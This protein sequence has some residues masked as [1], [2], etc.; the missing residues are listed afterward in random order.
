[1][2]E[3]GLS[4][5]LLRRLVEQDGTRTFAHFVGADGQ[6]KALLWGE[7]FE[8][9]SSFARF[10]EAAG[11]ERRETVF[12]L[13]P[14]GPELLGA[15]IGAM[16]HRAL[17]ALLSYPSSKVPP[18]VYAKNLRGVL[19]VTGARW[20]VTTRAL[21]GPVG[22]ALE[23]ARSRVLWLEDRKP[24][25]K[26]TLERHARSVADVPPDEVALLQHSSGSTGLQKGVALSHRSVLR[27]IEHYARAIDLDPEKDVIASWLPLYHDMGLIATFL[28]PLATGTRAV[29]MDPFR[30]VVEPAILL[31]AIARHR[32]SLVWLPNFAYVH[33]ASRVPPSRTEHLDLS[34]MRGF[35]NC[36][37]PVRHSAHAAFLERY[38][39]N[40]VR[41]DALWV[42]YAMAENTFAVTHAGG[43]TERRVDWIDP[44]AFAAERVA[45]PTSPGRGLAVVSCGRPI[46]GCEV[47]VVDEAR[48]PLP[49]RSVGEIALRSDSML[50]EYH[51]NPEATAKA[52]EGGFY[53]TGDLGY[54]ADGHLHVT[55]RRK[56]LI[57]VGGRNFYPQDLEDVASEQ[58][59]IVPGRTVAL[60]IENAALGTEE[61]VV[62]AESEETD[63][64]KRSAIQ[65]AVQR[66]AL[67]RLD[68]AVAR[69]ELVPRGWILKTSSGKVARR[70]NLEKYLAERAARPAAA[71]SQPSLA[72]L[73]LQVLVAVAVLALAVVLRPNQALVLYQGF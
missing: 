33:L 34:S 6:D 67:E 62:L 28:V 47:R 37:E 23:G 24:S 13:A 50:T 26:A 55:G 15:F 63:P 41:E 19:E 53:F 17:P 52:L 59:G 48:A 43:R 57:I 9:A 72:L 22:K 66:A 35:S 1:V 31:E 51:Q 69:V 42:C 71:A 4:G 54:L 64:G 44:T 18:D 65:R 25:D 38:A 46:E 39:K 32:A 73:A 8:L 45:R 49:E 29:Y 56:D 7:L 68:C 10:L 12:V 11:V 36:S 3:R 5:T 27:Q 14:L 61:V 30:W 21:E 60:G 40:G 58:A 2:E 20:V 16:L 70:A